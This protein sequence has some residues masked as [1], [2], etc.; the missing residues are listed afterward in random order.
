MPSN[1]VLGA[2]DAA[3]NTDLFESGWVRNTTE[4]TDVGEISFTEHS[5]DNNTSASSNASAHAE[6]GTSQR[7]IVASTPAGRESASGGRLDAAGSFRV[8]GY[9]ATAEAFEMMDP[10]VGL[11]QH[12]IDRL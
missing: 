11:E 10:W 9:V 2:A 1:S 5:G 4:D 12:N 6:E 7:R 3:E 8:G